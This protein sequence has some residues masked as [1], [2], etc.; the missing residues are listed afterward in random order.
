MAAAAAADA[1]KAPGADGEPPGG[2][3][4]NREAEAGAK[5]AFAPARPLSKPPTSA[6]ES[7][8]PDPRR[9]IPSKRSAAGGVGYALGESP[10][11][12]DLEPVPAQPAQ[13]E[14]APAPSTDAPGEVA[15]APEP[16]GAAA[17]AQL[18]PPPRLP[19]PIAGLPVPGVLP[20]SALPNAQSLPAMPM[21]PPAVLASAAGSAREQSPVS[22][23][24]ARPARPARRQTMAYLPDE[25][26]AVRA[27]LGTAS[28]SAAVRTTTSLASS[29]QDHLVQSEVPSMMI[30]LGHRD[31]EPGPE[32]PLTYR[33]R[34]YFWQPPAKRE[35]VERALRAELITL[36]KSLGDR[37]RGQYINLA[38]F[39]H[40]FE[41]KPTKAPV[42]TLQWKDWRGEPVFAW[43]AEP[44]AAQWTAPQ[45][46]QPV[47]NSFYPVP[48]SAA[49]AP[50][51][52]ASAVAASAV[53][54]S[55]VPSAP[56]PPPE[57][58]TQPTRRQ[59]LTPVPDN[60]QGKR[61]NTGEQDL[62]LAVAFEA[63]QDLYFLSTPADG[64]DFA[65]K[66]LGELVPAEAVSGCIYDINTDEFRFV[67]LSGTGAAERRAA[68]VR[69][70]AGL[71][72]VAARSGLDTLIV[73]DVATEPRYD[74]EAD[75]RSGLLASNMA[76]FVLH[77]GGQLFGMLQIINR[78]GPKGFREGDLAV[79]GYIANQ[80]TAFLREKR[81]LGGR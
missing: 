17:E 44:A 64:L 32:S 40:A 60:Q 36:R 55:A 19:E 1:S 14:L 67:A 33:E 72:A 71:F 5:V 30:T 53:A 50:A 21:P 70:N 79:G 54:A 7:Q 37:Q 62:R 58:A 61:D 77:R 4:P 9:P 26:A 76:F 13:T 41:D 27:Q 38:V 45:A 31:E 3:E 34:S 12:P 73:P 46:D 78:E 69:G 22:E 39:D 63:A 56:A 52:S 47:A 35:E 42:A 20:A 80:V 18:P 74:P 10:S 29:A 43:L 68:A 6:P 65:V 15:P 11:S 51:S 75:G 16:L 28:A 48:P 25:A 23:A 59:A 24:P 8:R 81:G 57:R 66:L 2:R 49:P